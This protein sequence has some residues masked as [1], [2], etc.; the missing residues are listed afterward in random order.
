MKLSDSVE[1]EKAA[2]EKML[3]EV[4]SISQLAGKNTQVSAQNSHASSQL[5]QQAEHLK[6][7]AEKFR[8]KE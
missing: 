8:L 5:N 4:D 2:L 1:D 7:L 3:H 6:A